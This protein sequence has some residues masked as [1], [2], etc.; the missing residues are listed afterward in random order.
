MRNFL[1]TQVTNFWNDPEKGQNFFVAFSVVV[2]FGSLSC[3]LL[4]TAAV[5]PSWVRP[6]LA[7]NISR[8]ICEVK[9]PQAPSVLRSGMTRETGVSYSQNTVFSPLDRTPGGQRPSRHQIGLNLV[10]LRKMSN[11]DLVRSTSVCQT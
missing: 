11:G 10:F 8:P 5:S 3:S 4:R 6:Y 9:Q 7:E 2:S 1:V